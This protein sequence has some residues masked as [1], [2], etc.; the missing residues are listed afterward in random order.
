MKCLVINSSQIFFFPRY[1]QVLVSWED[2][3]V[4][5]RRLPVVIANEV[6][7]PRLLCLPADR[8]TDTG[9][10]AGFALFLLLFLLTRLRQASCQDKAPVRPA[11]IMTSVGLR[12]AC[13]PLEYGR[14]VLGGFFD[15]ITA[16][17]IFVGKN[18]NWRT[19]RS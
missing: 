12:H 19:M 7:L 3:A 17:K 14:Q 13:F 6:L 8:Q 15:T 10:G 5:F 1:L 11:K 18:V 4:A 2:F 16:Y 9:T